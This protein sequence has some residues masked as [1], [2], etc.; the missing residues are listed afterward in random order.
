[1]LTDELLL[2]KICIEVREK[3]LKRDNNKCVICQSI[4]SVNV[5]YITDYNNLPCEGRVISNAI[6]L[7]KE[8][9]KAA[10]LYL[11]RKKSPRGNPQLSNPIFSPEE[12][13]KA[14]DSSFTEAYVDCL[15]MKEKLF[16][17]ED[18]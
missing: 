18:K 7:C 8:C 14:I 6:S 16:N 5:H 3:A 2:K 9:H 12:L 11:W 4:N 1:M 17:G 15:K 10:E 13:Y